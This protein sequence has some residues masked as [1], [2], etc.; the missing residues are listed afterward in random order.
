MLEP[1]FVYNQKYI[2]FRTNSNTFWTK[3]GRRR[4]IE[5]IIVR[6]SNTKTH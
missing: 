2:P 4:L 5:E 6:K 3:K 1:T